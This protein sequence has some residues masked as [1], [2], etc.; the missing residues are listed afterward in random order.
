[1]VRTWSRA[2]LYLTRYIALEHI[3]TRC[4][5]SDSEKL[6][7]FQYRRDSL[8]QTD[9]VNHVDRFRILGYRANGMGRRRPG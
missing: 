9:G 4:Q 6:T 7:V 5:I 2:R 8:C 3:T 1:M